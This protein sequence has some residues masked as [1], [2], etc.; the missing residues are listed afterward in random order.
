MYNYDDGPPSNFPPPP[1][2]PGSRTACVHFSRHF[3][4]CAALELLP[5]LDNPSVPFINTSLA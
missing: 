2:I 3:S 4:S 1:P 5:D